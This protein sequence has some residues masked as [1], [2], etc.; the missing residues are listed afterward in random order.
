MLTESQ[1]INY[2]NNLSYMDKHKVYGNYVCNMLYFNNLKEF[3]LKF[4]CYKEEHLKPFYIS[5]FEEFT[6]N[7]NVINHDVG[8]DW[9]KNNFASQTWIN[10]NSDSIY[11]YIY[12]NIN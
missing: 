6:N 2:V 10:F 1:T 8:K 11:N 12:K 3:K 4:D 9:K 7:N 5:S